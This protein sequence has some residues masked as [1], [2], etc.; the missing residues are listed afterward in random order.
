MPPDASPAATRDSISTVKSGAV[1]LTSADIRDKLA[2][3]LVLLVASGLMVRSYHEL[4]SVDPGVD[5]VGV[6]LL[7]DLDA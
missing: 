2:M 5:A 4:R 1:A 7:R 3:A 6:T